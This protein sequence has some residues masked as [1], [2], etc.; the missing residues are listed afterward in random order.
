MCGYLPIFQLILLLCEFSLQLFE[1]GVVLLD[2]VILLI[3]LLLKRFCDLGHVFVV[4][5][6]LL[7]CP[8]HFLL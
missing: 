4:T 2:R 7:T 1:L 5:L 6:D 8:G 3:D